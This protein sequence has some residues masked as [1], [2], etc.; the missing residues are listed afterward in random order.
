LGT[1]GVRD[2]GGHHGDDYDQLPYRNWYWFP[3][4]DT[5]VYLFTQV[6]GYFAVRVLCRFMLKGALPA[7]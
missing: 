5:T 6:T 3:T 2:S 7:A 1:G 4:N